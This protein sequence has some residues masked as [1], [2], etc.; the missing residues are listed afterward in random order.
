MADEHQSARLG[1]PVGHVRATTG[2]EAVT[3]IR[4]I[5]GRRLSI[6]GTWMGTKGELHELMR[7]VDQ[8]RL[9]PVVH[10]VFSLEEAVKAQEV[11]ER[12]EHFGKLVLMVT[13]DSH[14]PS[15]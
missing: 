12:S 11:M 10:A 9:K 1:R 5:F 2:A 13:R 15:R 4:Y 3:D 7:L 14:S 6:H 8:G